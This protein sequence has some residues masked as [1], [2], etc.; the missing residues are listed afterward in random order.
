MSPPEPARAT[1]VAW[2]AHRPAV[3][4]ELVERLQRAAG[5]GFTP[6]PLPDVHATVIGLEAA[7][8][9]DGLLHHLAAELAREPLQVRFGGFA[10]DDLRLRS[11][12]L[13]LAERS[14]GVHGGRLVLIGW[15]VDPEPSPRLGEIRLR[16]ERFGFRHKYHERP[17]DLDP[18]AYLVLGEAPDRGS[19]DA[20]RREVLAAPVLVPLTVGD[21]ALVEYVDPRLPAASSTWWPLTRW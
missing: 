9:R 4:T 6:R 1:V 8:D 13:T 17:G 15:P 20:M 14:L 18:D 7:G 21:V 19:V 10:G 11:R 3:L 2:Y 16:C 12:G 5:P